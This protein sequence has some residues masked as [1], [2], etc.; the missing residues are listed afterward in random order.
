V[1]VSIDAYDVVIIGGGFAGQCFARHLLRLRPSTKVAIVER[2]AL[3]CDA[4]HRGVGESTS[5]IAAWY[6]RERLGLGEHLEREQVVKFGLRF[7]LRDAASSAIHERVELGLMR[8]PLG[9]TDL[10]LPLDPHTYQLHRGRLE[11]RLALD[12]LAAG[13]NLLAEH[14]FIARAYEDRDGWCVDLRG[15]N[16]SERRIRAAWLV[17]ASGGPQLR[18]D[19]LGPPLRRGEHRIAAAWWWVDARLDPASWTA[20]PEVDGRTP[21]ELRWRSTH[22]LVG[23]GYWVWLIGLAD[24]STSVG[25]VVDPE[26]HPLA[27]HDDVARLLERCEP[28]LVRA[29][30][31]RVPDAIQ[32]WAAPGRVCVEPLGAR[33]VNSGAALGFLDPLY[34]AGH[35]LTAVIHE[36]TI[37]SL[38][39]ALE[40]GHGHDIEA[41][42]R[43]AI[44]RTFGHIVEHYERLYLGAY[45]LFG[46]PA[47]AGIKFA[48]DQLNY[49]SWPCA[50]TFSGRLGDREFVA[51]SRALADRVHVL[52]DRVQALL[53]AWVRMRAQRSPSVERASGR[54]IDQAQL[55]TVM[56][57]FLALRQLADQDDGEL[58]AQLARSIDVLE[59]FAL[60]TLERACTDLDI[61]VPDEPLDPYAI[62]L[63]PKRWAA[64]GLFAR[65]RG[66]RADPVARED[67]ERLCPSPPSEVLSSPPSELL[68]S[69]RKRGSASSSVIDRLVEGSDRVVSLL[70]DGPARARTERAVLAFARGAQLARALADLGALGQALALEHEISWEGA[71]VVTALDGRFEALLAAER[72]HA[73]WLY[74]GLGWADALTLRGA[75]VPA[76]DADEAAW[77]RLDGCGFWLGLRHGARIGEA[78]HRPASEHAAAYFDQGVGRSLYFVHGGAAAAL[79]RA[80]AARGQR[81]ARALWIGVGI[82]AQI[83]GGIGPRVPDELD[84][85]VAV[86]GDALRHGLALGERLAARVGPSRI[87]ARPGL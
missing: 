21:P 10:P 8:P 53:R 50:L 12:N 26:Q 45:S 29:I 42:D 14:E 78:S 84:T 38:V 75:V 37:P 11:H 41:A 56:Q 62:S 13:A 51:R 85:L 24:G 34:S 35:D 69:P 79:E 80:V 28:E 31:G 76:R 61:E 67:L 86:G 16:Q 55:V 66:R 63:D 19:G 30:G 83:T 4:G 9:R 74:I 54:G 47:V 3:P 36:L 7:W 59:G 1:R 52:N 87:S 48:W 73:A 18:D 46:D 33:R 72:E 32:F 82:A 40:R 65:R 23:A 20:D 22:H 5:E 49:F 60:A 71:G 25:L 70:G 2:R 27:D 44:N 57:R 39:A 81:R 17:D 64:D 68:S 77:L 6:L 15:P 58:Q 43:A